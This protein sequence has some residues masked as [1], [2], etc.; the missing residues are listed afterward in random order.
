MRK[1]K[2]LISLVELAERDNWICHICKLRVPK[3]KGLHPKLSPTRDHVIPVALK[4]NDSDFLDNIKLAHRICNQLKGDSQ[5]SD[6]LRER[7]KNT[8]QLIH[9]Q[10]NPVWKN[11]GA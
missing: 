7:C 3:K 9:M 11:W 4:P 6:D 10:F 1:D 8:I 2:Q 5:L